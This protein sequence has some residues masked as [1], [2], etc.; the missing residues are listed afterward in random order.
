[1]QNLEPLVGPLLVARRLSAL[2]RS[3]WQIH[4]PWRLKR[5]PG[6]ADLHTT[7]LSLR[8]VTARLCADNGLD[9]ETRGPRPPAGCILVANHLSYIDTLVLPSLVHGTVIAKREVLGWPLI[10]A[11]V[12]KLG[13]LFVERDCPW[14]GALVLRQAMRAVRAGLTL[15]AFPEGSTTRGDQLLPFRRGVFGLARRLGVPVVAA[16]LS[17]EDP[18]LTWIGD[19]EFLG[20]YLDRVARKRRTSV[21]L[22]FS[23]PFDP[24]GWPS[25]TAFADRVRQHIAD[26]MATPWERRPLLVRDVSRSAP[27]RA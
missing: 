8:S 13:V 5:R 23:A 15:V 6:P 10:G 27:V 17:Y 9:V 3:W 2:A 7:A 1:M 21:R 22:T 26:T 12:Q 20:H 24:R 18:G 19:E 4:E 14:S 11:M 25:A 16:T